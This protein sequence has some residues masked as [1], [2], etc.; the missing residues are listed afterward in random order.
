MLRLEIDWKT[1][2]QRRRNILQDTGLLCERETNSVAVAPDATEPE[3]CRQSTLVRLWRNPV[4][5]RSS[6][7][8]MVRR[9]AAASWINHFVR[10]GQTRNILLCLL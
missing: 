3:F 10:Y 9:N 6:L 2:G 8:G 1:N 4:P 5:P 7:R